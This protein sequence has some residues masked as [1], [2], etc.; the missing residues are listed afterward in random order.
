MYLRISRAFLL[1]AAFACAVPLSSSAAESYVQSIKPFHQALARLCPQQHLENL[2]PGILDTII[3]GFLDT[4]PARTRSKIERAAQ[5]MC[6]KSAA[7]VSCSNIAT[8][9]AARK[10]QMTG[11]LA[12]AACESGYVC[13]AAFDCAN[14]D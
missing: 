2:T 13:R 1:G 7:G 4:L 14:K 8:I 5:P 10:L 6:V 12:K 9:R 11:R 3:E